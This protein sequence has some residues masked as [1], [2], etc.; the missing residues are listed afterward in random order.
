[1]GTVSMGSFSD[2]CRSAR[3]ELAAHDNGVAFYVA[4]P[5]STIDWTISDGRKGIPIDQHNMDEVL[6]VQGIGG[7][8]IPA[9]VRLTSTSEALN[10]PFDINPKHLV[11][12]LFTEPGGCAADELQLLKLSPENCTRAYLVDS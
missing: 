3:K 9:Q 1:M 8:N 11:T 12:G 10:P 5:S 4:L 6:Y 2:V 7:D